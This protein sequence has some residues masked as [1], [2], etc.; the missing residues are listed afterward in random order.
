MAAKNE[1]ATGPLHAELT[2]TRVFRCATGI[3]ELKVWTDSG[4]S[5]PL[6]GSGH[7]HHLRTPRG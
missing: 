2:F 7:V 4:A 5:G 3:A 6:V 1:H